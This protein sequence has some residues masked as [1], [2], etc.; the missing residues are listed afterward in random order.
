MEFW[1][2]RE[3]CEN[4]GHSPSQQSRGGTMANPKTAKMKIRRNTS[5]DGSV[6]QI[7]FWCEN[8]TWRQKLKL[9]DAKPQD[10]S[11]FVQLSSRIKWG[12]IQPHVV[13]PAIN[14]KEERLATYEHFEVLPCIAHVHMTW[15]RCRFKSINTSSQTPILQLGRNFGRV[16]GKSFGSNGPKKYIQK[17]TPKKLD[18]LRC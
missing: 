5:L 14:R 2:R 3:T 6:G 15:Q 13:I 17:S 8:E 4:R 16:L 7:G 12:R 18:D 1:S 11:N 9:L 10:L